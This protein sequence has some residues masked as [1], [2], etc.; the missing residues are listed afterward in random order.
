M[1][2]NKSYFIGWDHFCSYAILF[3][4]GAGRVIPDRAVNSFR[5]RNSFDQEN[6]QCSAGRQLVLETEQRVMYLS[7][8]EYRSG[9]VGS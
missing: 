2:I 3:G 1:C 6:H 7:E 4:C 5:D 8:A 9:F